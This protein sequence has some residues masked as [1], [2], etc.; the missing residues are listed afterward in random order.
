MSGN[1]VRLARH[2]GRLRVL[3]VRELTIWVSTDGC[4]TIKSLLSKWRTTK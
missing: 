4:K 2:W 1:A 3:G